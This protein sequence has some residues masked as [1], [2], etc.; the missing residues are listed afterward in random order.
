SSH[1]PPAGTR[2]TASA[3]PGAPVTFIKPWIIRSRA[4]VSNV[5]ILCR[6]FGRRAR[7][8]FFRWLLVSRRLVFRCQN[9]GEFIAGDRNGQA[10]VTA[11]MR[12]SSRREFMAANRVKPAQGIRSGRNPDNKLGRQ[13]GVRQIEGV[14]LTLIPHCDGGN[15]PRI[16][17][18][19]LRQR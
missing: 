18:E 2:T 16:P 8:T 4:A 10:E 1:P 7:V 13:S 6:T 15:I 14:S 5:L 19:Y 17:G 11:R 12:D 9:K 3:A